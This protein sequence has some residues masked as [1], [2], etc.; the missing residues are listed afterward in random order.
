[1]LDELIDEA[2]ALK[3]NDAATRLSEECDASSICVRGEAS[4]ILVDGREQTSTSPGVSY[5]LKAETSGG[6]IP[7]VIGRVD[8][9]NE[10]RCAEPEGGWDMCTSF[11]FPAPTRTV[12]SIW[13]Y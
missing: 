12:A 10:V 5:G 4:L 7:G 3:V 8:E 9:V 6:C 13:R 11:G 2:R 1:M